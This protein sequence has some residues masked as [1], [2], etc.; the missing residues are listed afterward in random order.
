MEITIM[1]PGINPSEIPRTKYKM[2]IIREITEVKILKFE[3]KNFLTVFKFIIY[4]Q[5]YSNSLESMLQEMKMEK[6]K[7]FSYLERCK[8]DLD[9][10][11]RKNSV[12]IF[13]I[14]GLSVCLLHKRLLNCLKL[15][16]QY[17]IK[18]LL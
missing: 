2:E 10:F 5:N 11:L 17:L 8:N 15:L 4:F 12:F 3:L 16:Q 1:I 9:L 7:S 6:S 14:P 13:L 18:L